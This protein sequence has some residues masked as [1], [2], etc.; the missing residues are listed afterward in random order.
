M[1]SA[2]SRYRCARSRSWRRADSACLRSRISYSSLVE[3][4]DLARQ[5]LGQLLIVFAEGSAFVA[6]K[7][8]PPVDLRRRRDRRGEKSLNLRVTGGE[9]ER[10]RIAA[11][12]VATHGSSRRR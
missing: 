10:G 7:A 6:D 9:L 11:G 8:D 3:A 1:T 2:V 5:R 4:A 12:I